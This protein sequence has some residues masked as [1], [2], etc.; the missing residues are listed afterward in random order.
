MGVALLALA[1][2]R[3]QPAAVAVESIWNW[4]WMVDGFLEVPR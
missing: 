1:P 3:E 4:N 2:Y